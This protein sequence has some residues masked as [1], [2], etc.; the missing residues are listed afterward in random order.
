MSFVNSTKSLIF[1]FT[2]IVLP[3]RLI[4]IYR[5]IAKVMHGQTLY[6][7]LTFLENESVRLNC[8]PLPRIGVL[9]FPQVISRF[10]NT[11]DL[12]EMNLRKDNCLYSLHADGIVSLN[13]DFKM[14]F[15]NRLLK[16]SDELSSYVR[17][18]LGSH[19][20]SRVLATY[21]GG[22]VNHLKSSLNYQ[23]Y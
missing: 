13:L 2:S 11:S 15:G 23:Q 10:D 12:I 17:F 7:E 21:H 4:F 6:T 3:K 18:Y 16:L 20:P 5:L 1:D 22:K 9:H 8:L 19:F 14:Q